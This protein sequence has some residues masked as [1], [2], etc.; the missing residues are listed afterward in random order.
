MKKGFGL[1]TAMLILILVAVL[2]NVVVKISFISVKHT[3]DSYLRERA[4]LFMQSSIENTLL[5]IEGYKRNSSCLKEINFTDEDRR[6]FANV[7]ILRYYCYD[8]NDC[9]CGN[10]AK[11]IDTDFSNGYVLLDVLV[12]SNLS[13]KKNN[14]KLI[15]L[16]KITLQRP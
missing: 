5:A 10:L 14:N 1:A 13:N 8:L 2:L 3:S 6:F 16:E 11:K 9:P 7:K 4:E 15:R 12:E